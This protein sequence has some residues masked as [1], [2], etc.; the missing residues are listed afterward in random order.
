MHR[1]V[2]AL[3]WSVILGVSALLVLAVLLPRL[4]GATPYA[5]L[6]GSMEPSLRPGSLVVTKPLPADEIAIGD[7]ITYQLESG[8]PTV[9]THRVVSLG[10]N[11]EGDRVWTT[12]GDANEVADAKPVRE[13]QVRGEVWY[14]IPYVGYVHSLLGGQQRQWVVYAVAFGL[15][16]YAV[17]MFAGASRDRRRRRVAVEA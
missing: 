13:P 11:G 15:L 5:V 6:S 8:R 16:G 17:V 1:L 12:R 2:S 10:V 7:V 14:S 3:A 9:V 4:A